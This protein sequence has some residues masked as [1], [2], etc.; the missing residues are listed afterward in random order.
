MERR[1]KERIVKR[2]EE[3]R[4][5]FIAI[6]TVI[7]TLLAGTAAAQANDV[8]L[9]AFET[10]HTEH[11]ATQLPAEVGKPVQWVKE[12]EVKNLYDQA[13]SELTVT[14]PEDAENIVATDKETDAPVQTEIT[15]NEVTITDSLDFNEQKDY[16]IRYETDAPEKTESQLQRQGDTLVK[17]V[18]VSSDHHYED[19]LTYTDIPATGKADAG[20]KIL[21]YW[22][23]NGVKTDVTN[24]PELDVKFYDTDNDGMYD[25][26]S[27]ITPH[28]STQIFEIVIYSD[29]DPGSYSSIGLSLNYPADAQYIT[30]TSRVNFNYSVSYNSSTTVYCN[31]TVDSIVKRENIPTLADTEIT[32]YFNLSSGQHTW[33]VNCA[34]DD[35]AANTSATRT[36]TIDLDQPTINLNTADY[37]VSYTNAIQLNFTPVDEKYSTLVCSLSVNRVLNRTGIVAMNNTQETVQLTALPNGVY[38]WNVSCSDAA[39]NLGRSE[40]RVFYISLGTPSAYNISPNKQSYGL[41]EV[42]YYIITANAGSNVT[43]FVETPLHDSFFRYYNGRTFPLIDTINFTSNAGTYNIDAIFSNSGSMYVVKTA[44]TA[45]SSFVADI[46]A[47][48]T[49]GRPGDSFEFEAN[50]TGG[51]GGVTYEWD[52]GDGTTANGTKTNHTYS[53]VGEY[54]LELTATDSRNNKATETL[55]IYIQRLHELQ[56]IVKELQTKKVLAN[57]PVEVDDERKNTDSDGKVNYTVYEGKRRIYVALEGYEWVK[58]VRNI[59]ED[60]TITIELNNTAITNYTFDETAEQTEQQEQDAKTEAENMLADI[61]TALEEMDPDDQAT[62]DILAALD[63][64]AKLQQAAKELRQMIRDLGNAET[65]TDLT[66]EQRAD[67]IKNITSNLD[68]F[69]GI[70]TSVTV[71]DTTEFADYPKATDIAMIAEEYLRYKK[72][73]YSKSEKAEYIN[74][75]TKLQ[76]EATITTRLAIVDLARL[77]GTTSKAAVVINKITKRP[78]STANTVLIEYL[79]KEVAGNVAEVKK[80]TEFE[81]VKADPILKFSPDVDSYT[82]YI[83]KELALDELEKT[84][85]IFL[86]EPAANDK[87]L[88]KVTGLSILPFLN[89]DDPKLFAEIVIIA[90]LLLAYLVYHFELID[91]IRERKKTKTDYAD[92]AY[93]PESTFDTITRKARALVDEEEKRIM[94][95]VAHIKSLLTSMHRH[96][97]TG[98]HDKAHETYKHVTGAYKLL[99]QEAKEHIHPETSHVYN[100]LLVAKADKLLN[101]AFLDVDNGEHKT[102]AS[103]YSEIKKIYSQMEKEHRAAVSDRCIKLHEKLFESTLT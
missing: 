37:Y 17:N 39:G 29:V 48:Q 31:L 93:K 4:Q 99:S 45:T 69:K 53:T 9:S 13:V 97:E 77:S 44:I 55:R 11:G 89:V 21:L 88:G 12:V 57:I 78:A 62:K 36:F 81:T 19:V 96:I 84:K 61:N 103:H 68:S 66:P 52:F 82:Y 65:A 47:E 92:S 60:T 16:L 50:A 41:G 24:D 2:G 58:Q 22:Q 46:D 54:T 95:E 85:H 98:Q 18:I 102:A 10:P 94:D 72:I 38:N 73:E 23:I 40:E 87:G 100:K 14:V 71:E 6:L 49:T 59:T 27:W 90:I 30:S 8:T 101:E 28:L 34:G 79:P 26:M 42:G 83:E 75:N 51:I 3:K 76:A 70:I 67:R 56:I 35:G 7:I 33:N 43:L 15:Q 5:L 64:E 20:E 32:T 1:S 25:R 86:K 63:V 80:V 91:K 74:A